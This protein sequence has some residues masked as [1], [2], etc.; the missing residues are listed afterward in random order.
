MP[1]ND[2]NPTLGEQ[3]EED[4][5]IRFYTEDLLK[6]ARES[7]RENKELRAALALILPLAKG[8]VATHHV[9]SN[10]S[11]IDTASALLSPNRDSNG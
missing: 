9:G 1:Y 2:G 3:I 11:Y 5:R 7:V 10:Q 8:Y 4:A 6:E